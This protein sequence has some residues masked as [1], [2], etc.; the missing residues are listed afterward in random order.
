M[1]HFDGPLINN[2]TSPQYRKAQIDNY[3]LNILK[4]ADRFVELK[5]NV[6]VE[7]KNFASYK[8]SVYLIGYRYSKQEHFYS[9]PYS[10][11][12]LNIQYIKKDKNLLEMWNIECIKRKLVVLPYQKKLISFP[13]LHA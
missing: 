8:N 11:S 5:T 6:I 2:C 3:Y 1:E 4:I 7:I 13:L 12:L 9:K 10:S